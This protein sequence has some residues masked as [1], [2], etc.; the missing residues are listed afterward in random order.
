[1]Y[2]GHDE[3]LRFFGTLVAH[4]E[5]RVEIDRL[6]AAGDTVVENGRTCGRVRGSGRALEIDETHVWRVRDAAG[7]AQ[8]RARTGPNLR[9]RVPAPGGTPK[10][11]AGVRARP[12]PRGKDGLA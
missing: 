9:P 8:P 10:Q 5:T 4:I 1:M 11:G 2:H 12:R 3:A 7:H 6:I